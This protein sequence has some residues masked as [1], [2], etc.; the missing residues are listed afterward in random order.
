MWIFDE[1]RLSFNFA[2]NDAIFGKVILKT[3]RQLRSL[4]F[5]LNLFFAVAE[6]L[7]VDSEFN[8]LVVVCIVAHN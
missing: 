6:A 7:Y 8:D 1:P 3:K 2:I 5:K 4:E